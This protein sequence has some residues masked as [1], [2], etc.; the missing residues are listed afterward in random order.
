MK[1]QQGAEPD[2]DR[3]GRLAWS[4]AETDLR[5]R[6]FVKKISF[7]TCGAGSRGNM[8]AGSAVKFAENTEIVGVAEPRDYYRKRHASVH[9][10]PSKDVFTDW[11]PMAERERFADAVIIATQDNMHV[12]PAKAFA[13]KGYHILLE[14]PVAPTWDECVEVG[15]AV[16]KAGVI[17]GVCHGLRYTNYS[18]KIKEI[19]DSGAIG[20]IVAIQHV[21]PV[22]YWHY[23]HSY[24][25]GNWR[26]EKESSFMLLAKSCHDIDLMYYWLNEESCKAVS[27]FGSLKHFRPECKPAGAADRCLDCSVESTCPYS[28]KRHYIDRPEWTR[29]VVSPEPTDENVTDALRTGPY[30][31]CVYACDN[32]VVDNQVVNLKFAGGQTV[33]FMMVAFTDERGR[34]TQIFGSRGQLTGRNQKIEVFDFMTEETT[35]FD[36]SAHNAGITGG[37]GGGDYNLMS[38]F[39]EAIRKDDQSLLSSGVDETLASHR[40]VFA[41]EESRL[42]NR[43]VTL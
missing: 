39:V 4:L 31:R 38:S 8:H 34:S 27:S 24:V 7:I 13:A 33:S 25:R 35:E 36:P 9:N 43:V 29:W 16:K 6:E 41:A 32:D 30:G 42:Q 26:N 23:C 40:T 2:A 3:P 15:D 22:G 14:K 28:A 12:E 10:I 20:D 37:H 18:R 19:I 1:R 5:R 17:L 21:E 11:H